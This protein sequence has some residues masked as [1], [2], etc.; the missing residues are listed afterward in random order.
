MNYNVRPNRFPFQTTFHVS[1]SKDVVIYFAG[2]SPETS[3]NEDDV[4]E[5]NEAKQDQNEAKEDP[6]EAE[7]EQN[8]AKEDPNVAEQ[9]QNEADS[10][11]GSD[12]SGSGLMGRTSPVSSVGDYA[13]SFAVDESIKPDSCNTTGKKAKG[14]KKAEVIV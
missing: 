12:T 7:Q 3:E 4:Q 2:C 11:D 14:K 8:E 6:N 13:S 5:H 10:D 1:Y 9:E